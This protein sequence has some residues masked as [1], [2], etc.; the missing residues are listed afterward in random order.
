MT[1]QDFINQNS[2]KKIG[3]GQCGDL[4]DA[5]LV[6]VF[7]NHTSYATALDYWTNGIPGFVVAPQPEPGDIAC[8]N[9]HPGFPAGHIAIYAGNGEV[10]EQNA[11]PDGSPA[12]LYPRAN[13]YLLGYLRGGNMITKDDENVMSILATGS[14]PGADYN[15]QFTGTSNI[16][17]MVNFWLNESKTAG[18]LSKPTNTNVVPYSGPQLFVKS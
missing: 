15:Y 3:S 11:D 17:G 4:V 7:N 1:L 5:Y 12:H 14:Y 10:F 6:D 9:A 13:T 2:G 18:L 16:D 8:Y